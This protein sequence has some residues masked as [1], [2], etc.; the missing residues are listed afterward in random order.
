M[1]K[2]GV[3]GAVDLTGDDAPELLYVAYCCDTPAKPLSSCDYQCSRTYRKVG[4]AWKTDK[5]HEPC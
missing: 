3:R 5:Q 2:Q 1:T 4:A